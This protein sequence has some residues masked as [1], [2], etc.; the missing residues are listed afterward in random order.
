MPVAE[1]VTV[2]VRTG[3]G[4][5]V[6]ETYGDRRRHAHRRGKQG[7]QTERFSDSWRFHRVFLAF[8]G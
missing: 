6:L 1:I 3:G 7:Q 5:R 8:I 4:V 2:K